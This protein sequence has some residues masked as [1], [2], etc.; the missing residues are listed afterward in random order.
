MVTH[1]CLRSAIFAVG[2]ALAVA[3]GV[4]GTAAGLA[5]P[6][7]ALGTTGRGVGL[8]GLG[9]ELL[10]AA[11]TVLGVTLGSAAGSL[12]VREGLAA[13]TTG[14]T[15][16]AL[17]AEGTAG[18][19][20]TVLVLV[21]LGLPVPALE[22]ATVP[23]GGGALGA[24]LF[25]PV[26]VPAAVGTAAVLLELVLVGTAAT[27]DEVW[28]GVP[29][30][31]GPTDTLVLELLVVV[32]LMGDARGVAA[33]LDST[34][35]PGVLDADT[36]GRGGAELL[37]AGLWDAVADTGGGGGA[38]DRVLV[39]VGVVVRVTDTRDVMDR[40]VVVD[41]DFVDVPL[42][43]RVLVRVSDLDAVSV[44]VDEPDAVE[45]A[46]RVDVVDTVG[47]TDLVMDLVMDLV[48]LLDPE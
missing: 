44:D 20:V 18:R 29:A 14:G 2:E 13:T 31:E 23:L 35:P 34:P 17:E 24:T 41:A 4:G 46:D 25:V 27:G 10:V 28:P 48:V 16:G 40:V 7:W 43:V 26:S 3:A 21:W 6:G 22:G 45:V 37:V 19:G 47:V 30:L 12:R 38:P 11:V 33:A 39:T 42:G 9:L 5:L 1:S 36:V 15:V 32:V 8:L